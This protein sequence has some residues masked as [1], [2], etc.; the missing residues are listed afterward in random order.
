MHKLADLG[1]KGMVLSLAL[2]GASLAVSVRADAGNAA[3]SVGRITTRVPQR[4]D[5]RRELESAVKRELGKVDLKGARGSGR[6]VLSASLVK[7]ETVTESDQAEA[8]CVVSA[9]LTRQKGGAL[10]AVLQGRARAIDSKDSAKNA[11]VEALRA[12]VRSAIGRVPEAIR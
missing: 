9:T 2:I 6:Y 3:V 12:A 5:V 4:D 11:E 1:G 7:M 10:H 8:T